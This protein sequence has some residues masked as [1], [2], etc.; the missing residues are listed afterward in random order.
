MGAWKLK[1]SLKNA[2]IGWR[3]EQSGATQS[4]HIDGG[5]GA[6]PLPLGNFFFFFREKIT[7]STPF[8][9]HFARC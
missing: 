6:K 9:S 8:E 5:L 2:L 1:K 4:F 3:A 7:I